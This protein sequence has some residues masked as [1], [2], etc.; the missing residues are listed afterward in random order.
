M[1][2][3]VP[4]RH[5]NASTRLRKP[6]SESPLAQETQPASTLNI[7]RAFMRWRSAQPALRWGDIRFITTPEPVLAFT[8]QFEDQT[9]LAMFNLSAQAVAVNLPRDIRLELLEGHGL[10]SGTIQDHLMYL[11]AHGTV[12]AILDASA[13]LS[14]ERGLE[15]GTQ[16]KA[17]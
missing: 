6:L 14:I 1:P 10:R 12:F 2:G 8:R 4:W 3:G 15:S 17:Q 7:F 11:P 16:G 9:L 5:K 13:R